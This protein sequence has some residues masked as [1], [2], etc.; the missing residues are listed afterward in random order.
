MGQIHAGRHQITPCCRVRG[1]VLRVPRVSTRGGCIRLVGASS[2]CGR[3]GVGAGRAPTCSP[4]RWRT[5]SRPNP[6]ADPRGSFPVARSPRTGRC[7]SGAQREMNDVAIE[8][9]FVSS[10][11]GLAGEAVRDRVWRGGVRAV[12]DTG[13]GLPGDRGGV[14][15]G[16]AVRTRWLGATRFPG[17]G[18][19]RGRAV[20]GTV[21]FVLG[22]DLL[23]R[24]SVYCWSF[25][26]GTQCRAHR[27]GRQLAGEGV[28]AEGCPALVAG[29]RRP[30]SRRAEP[31]LAS[32]GLLTA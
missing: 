5:A 22:D 15:A 13:P 23:W 14:E 27:L 31:L 20:A 8:G 4:R 25:A 30:R 9:D 3:A 1:A 12:A 28:G 7:A 26:R 11:R 19:R 6:R 18:F 17:R 10:G 32:A 16:P 2:E 29:G 21:I 24:Q